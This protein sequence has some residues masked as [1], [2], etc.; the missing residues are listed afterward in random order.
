M[1]LHPNSQSSRL[2]KCRRNNATYDSSAWALTA[3]RQAALLMTSRIHPAVPTLPAIQAHYLATLSGINARTAH[4]V[5][6]NQVIGLNAVRVEQVQLLLKLKK[7]RRTL[8]TT[9]T[10][11]ATTANR[12][13]AQ[14]LTCHPAHLCL[15]LQL[16]SVLVPLLPLTI[17][18]STSRGLL[19]T[20]L[21]ELAWHHVIIATL[22]LPATTRL[23]KDH[24]K[25]AVALQ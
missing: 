3:V 8:T 4:Q 24:T 16:S 17:S 9:A 5:A 21:L 7:A 10:P 11:I 12:S 15:T 20:P 2:W 1:R 22:S 19:L 13:R 23:L 25:K 14:L 6:H 18:T